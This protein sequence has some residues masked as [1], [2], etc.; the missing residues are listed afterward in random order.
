MIT[1]IKYGLWSE[2]FMKNLARQVQA[3]LAK[4]VNL[5]PSDIADQ[6]SVTEADVVFSLPEDMT[7]AINGNEAE[8]L[9]LSISGWGKVTTI[10]HALGSIF[11]VKASLPKGKMAHGYYNLFGKPGELDGHLRLDLITRIAL[12]SKPFRGKESYYI[13]FFIKS[14]QSM[15][16]IYLGRDQKRQLIPEQI[17]QFKQLVS[18]YSVVSE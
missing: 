13:G 16:K 7:V 4:N 6:L 5:L 12:V 15:F 9:L 18:K 11:E 1:I 10:V 17:V 8:N 3:C 14:G 2:S